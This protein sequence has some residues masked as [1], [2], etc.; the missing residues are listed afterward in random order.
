[1]TKMTLVVRKIQDQN[2]IYFVWTA[3]PEP[4]A[5]RMPEKAYPH[6]AEVIG[7]W[8]HQDFDLEGETVAEIIAAFNKVS[9]AQQR[10]AVIDEIHEFLQADDARVE[11]DFIRIFNPD[12]EPTGFAPS[13]RAFLEE[14]ARQ[15]ARGAA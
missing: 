9:T 7:G 2:R 12:I 4:R 6:L 3:Y 1:M 14:I 13:T 8:F 15:V 5:P 11:T 10:E